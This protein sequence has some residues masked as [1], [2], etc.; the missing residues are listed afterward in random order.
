M[1]NLQDA[2]EPGIALDVTT[3]MA[4]YALSKSC[5]EI[6][7]RQFFGELKLLLDQE[8]NPDKV[9]PL[10]EQ[11]KEAAVSLSNAKG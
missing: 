1:S 9:A 4:L 7:I 2:E 3:R 8:Y 10:L 5:G 6:E 11:Y